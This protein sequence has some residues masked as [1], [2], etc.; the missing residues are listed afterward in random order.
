MIENGKREKEIAIAKGNIENGIPF[1][2][3]V[4]DGGWNKRTYGHSYN[5]TSGVV[6]CLENFDL[7]KW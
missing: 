5:S 2:T 3:V 4:G 1:I 7:I 6:S